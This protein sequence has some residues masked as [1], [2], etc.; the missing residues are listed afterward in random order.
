LRSHGFRQIR[1]DR[2][3][4]ELALDSD[5][6]QP[7]PAASTLSPQLFADL[8]ARVSMEQRRRA[9]LNFVH[10]DRDTTTPEAMAELLAAVTRG[11]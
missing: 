1:V 10:D 8:F 7:H 9:L 2:T 6:I 4:G 5:G 3:E 11:A